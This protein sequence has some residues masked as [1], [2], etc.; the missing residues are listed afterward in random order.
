MFALPQYQHLADRGHGHAG[1]A[2]THRHP[3]AGRQRHAAP[4]ADRYPG[5][6]TNR[7]PRAAADRYAPAHGNQRPS[8]PRPAVDAGPAV[9]VTPGPHGH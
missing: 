1:A 9:R 3:A 2:R 8:H 7:Y 4:A 6:G 5:S